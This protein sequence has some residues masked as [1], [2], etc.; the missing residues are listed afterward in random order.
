MRPSAAYVALFAPVVAL[1]TSLPRDASADLRDL[2]TRA[3]DQWKASGAAVSAAPTRFI[4]DS[5]TIAIA[6]PPMAAQR[7]TTVALIGARGL[8]FHAK[9]GGATDAQ[10]EEEGPAEAAKARGASVAG[11]LELSHCD[12]A[13]ASSAALNRDRLIVTSDA[14]RGAIEVVV[15][16]SKAALPPLRTIFP[17]RTGGLIPASPE[18][19]IL[20]PLPAQARRA[21]GAEARARN[22]GGTVLPRQTWRAAEDG[23]GSGEVELDP[24]CHRLEVFG[25]DPRTGNS[26]RKFRLDID[27][28]LRD[29]DEDVILARD[30][31]EAPDGH[32]DACVGGTTLG[33]V[34]FAGA[35]P[36]GSVIVTHSSWPIP[37]HLPLLWGSG[38]KAKM[39]AALI[40]RSVIPPRDEPIFVAQGSAGLTPI[41]VPVQPG[42]CYLVVV[43][44][45][46]GNP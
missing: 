39:A 26:A 44:V 38:P 23:S 19:G 45:A 1:I 4:Y 33:G 20:P 41:V 35:V 3:N 28:E 30:R 2:G 14:G 7:C 9:F 8:S 21:D 22:E 43:G 11:L 36:G 24:G 37:A 46:H 25:T 16:H 18:P 42:A 5:E 15:A 32:L 27:A 12:A 13:K 17:E 29:A 31:T 34:A 6:L 10:E 40:A